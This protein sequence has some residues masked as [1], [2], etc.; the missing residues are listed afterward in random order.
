MSMIKHNYSDP[1]H[2]SI[3]PNNSVQI[4][5]VLQSSNITIQSDNA[6]TSVIKKKTNEARDDRKDAKG[7]ML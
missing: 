1:S 2:S 6:S 7:D 5:L 4:T 3:G